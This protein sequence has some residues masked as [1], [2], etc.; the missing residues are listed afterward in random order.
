[1]FPTVFVTRIKPYH[2]GYILWIRCPAC[3]KEHSHGE[4]VIS[5][6]K[7]FGTR[8]SHCFGQPKIEYRILLGGEPEL[9]SE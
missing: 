7:D 4:N 5:G 9:E 1:M 3:G 8:V 2:G 6:K